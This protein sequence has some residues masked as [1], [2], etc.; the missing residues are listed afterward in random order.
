MIVMNLLLGSVQS[1]LRR[2][3][4]RQHLRQRQRERIGDRRGF[5][6]AW[7]GLELLQALQFLRPV[8]ELGQQGGVSSNVEVRDGSP[9]S[10]A[11]AVWMSFESAHAENR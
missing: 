8:R 5:G 4:A 7:P 9:P 10:S 11:S 3:T 1:G 6:D 2:V